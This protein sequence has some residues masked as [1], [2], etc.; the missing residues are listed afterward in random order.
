MNLQRK[1]FLGMIT[2]ILSIA[3]HSAIAQTQD[4][5]TPNYQADWTRIAIPPTH[6]VS[7]IA[8]W[9]F[10]SASK[11]IVCDG[12][13]GHEWLR[14]NKEF[15]D[16]HFHVEWRF[17]KLDGSPHYNSG[18]FFRNDEQGIIWHQAQTS[19]EG[20]YLF[21]ET[22]IGGNKTSFNQMKEMKENRVKPAGEWNTYDIEC[23]K[24]VC[25]LAVNGEIVN[26]LHTDVVKGYV[27]LESEGFKIEFR[28]IEIEELH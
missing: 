5:V 13:G 25:T 17:A 8:Q 3:S 15:A 6:P 14:F 10:D 20:G 7:N 1:A 22:M 18:I 24:D 26:T 19:P 23:R 27:G 28:K 16:F 12:N 4:L 2:A 21:G 11:T 9:H